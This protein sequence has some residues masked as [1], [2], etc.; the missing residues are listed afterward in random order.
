MLA[1]SPL[2]V[3]LMGSMKITNK[4]GL[5]RTFENVLRNDDYTMGDARISVTGLLKPPRIGLLFQK[6]SQHIEI[7]VVD[8]IW[9]ILGR[10][11]H[12]IL[13]QGGDEQHLPEERLYA[14]VRGWRI[15]GQADLQAKPGNRFKLVDYKNTSAYA[16][17]HGKQE[18]EEQLNLYRW[19]VQINKLHEVDELEVCAIVRDWNR[20]EAK[21]K[22]WYPQQPVEMVPIRLWTM[23]EAQRFA[24]DRV[25]IHQEAISAA[26]MGDEPPPCTDQERWMRTPT[27]A[28]VKAGNKR[29]SRIFDD[30]SEAAE[31]ASN[32]GSDFVVE[33]REAEPVRCT[34]DYCHVSRWCKQYREWMEKKQ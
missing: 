19:L 12:K 32:R 16:V 13:E 15:S 34:G 28:V 6:H 3:N 23:D 22:Y 2:T 10:A 14:E 20:R 26:E 4:H 9:S 30:P 11:V 7:D 27:Y 33:T 24:E 25:R 29:A 18:W 5:P 17:I 8:Q 21:A 1:G 31:Y